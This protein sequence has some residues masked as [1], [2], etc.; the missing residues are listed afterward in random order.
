MLSKWFQ[1][2]FHVF[3]GNRIS[4]NDET[5]KENLR[6]S[7]SQELM[8]SLD[9]AGDFY[10]ACLVTSFANLPASFSSVTTRS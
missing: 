7:F 5:D 6:A 10:A 3:C 9:Q 4:P 1:T 8:Q 2:G